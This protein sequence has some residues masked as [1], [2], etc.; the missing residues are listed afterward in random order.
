MGNRWPEAKW[1]VS[2][3]QMSSWVI[4]Q[5][6]QLPSSSAS[7]SF[8]PIFLINTLPVN[9]QD[10]LIA[11]SKSPEEEQRI[12]TQ[13]M[14]NDEVERVSIVVYGRNS[15]DT[16]IHAKRTQLRKLGFTKVYL[17]LGGLFEWLLL[18]QYMGDAMFPLQLHPRIA[19]TSVDPFAFV[20]PPL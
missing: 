15:H 14:E 16:T 10:I 4:E 19:P 9:E 8:S 2:P 11:T 6:Q 5:Q 18:R 7:A 17:Y 13:W 1:F 3:I 12:I 20:P